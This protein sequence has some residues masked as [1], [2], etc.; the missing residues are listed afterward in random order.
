[1]RCRGGACVR[2]RRPGDFI[3]PLGLTGTQ[4]LSDYFI[5]RRVDRPMRDAVLLVARDSEILWAA[6]VGIS[7]TAKL[8]P[9]SRGLRLEAREY[10]RDWGGH[11]DA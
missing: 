11:E 4:S 8:R 3:R 2:R 9:G 6:G 5:N 1:M 7:E 10:R